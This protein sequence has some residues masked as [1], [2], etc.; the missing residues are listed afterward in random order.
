MMPVSFFF[1][2]E[3][4]LADSPAYE[5]WVTTDLVPLIDQQGLARQLEIYRPE[6]QRARG[7]REV[8]PALLIEIGYENTE[9]AL[10]SLADPEMKNAFAMVPSGTGELPKNC[11][12]FD[13]LHSPLPGSER[14]FERSAPLSVVVRYHRPAV[15][16]KAFTDFYIA[17]HP[18]VLARLPRVRNVLCYLPIRWVNNTGIPTSDCMIGNEAVFDNVDDLNAAMASDIGPELA[19]DFRRF[20]PFSGPSSHV[21]TR[22]SCLIRNPSA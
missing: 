18:P 4:S 13:V 22:R 9:A 2:I 1:T 6:P 21:V 10:R 15:S 12:L 7:F 17:N 5:A 14:P 3:G 11:D 16:E 19:E 8:P 20:P